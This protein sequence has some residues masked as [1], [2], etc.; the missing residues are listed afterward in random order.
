MAKS[1]QK[2]QKVPSSSG[3]KKRKNCRNSRLKEEKV[4]EEE[5]EERNH[6]AQ[7]SS[8]E[9]LTK[10]EL[11]EKKRRIAKTKEKFSFLLIHLTSDYKAK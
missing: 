8:F 4:K 6:E 9:R 1:V 5:I 2:V 3:E 11:I 7:K 10:C